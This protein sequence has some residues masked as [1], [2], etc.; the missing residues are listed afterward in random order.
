M[1]KIDKLKV[2]NWNTKGGWYYIN[3]SSEAISP[4]KS[5][6]LVPLTPK[7]RI[8]IKSYKKPRRKVLRK[9]NNTFSDRKV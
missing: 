5:I 8:N 1:I 9:L 3:Q 7:T 2:K 4:P 6:K